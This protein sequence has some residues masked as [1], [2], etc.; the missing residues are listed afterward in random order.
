MF[1][2]LI[3]PRLLYGPGYIDN[4]LRTAELACSK[5]IG[6]RSKYFTSSTLAAC[7]DFFF[8]SSQH[9][10]YIYIQACFSVFLFFFKFL[11]VL[12]EFLHITHTSPTH[13]PS[14]YLP[15]QPPPKIK[16]THKQTNKQQQQQSIENIS[17][18]KL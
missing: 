10:I 5:E 12:C 9:N 3:I 16:H 7:N 17:S 11:L 13:L 2:I 14:S 18:R 4:N 1:G 8:L 6:L 15:L